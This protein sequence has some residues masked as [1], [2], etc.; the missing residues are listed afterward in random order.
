VR[1]DGGLT[2]AY[3]RRAVALTMFLMVD[4]VD[5]LSD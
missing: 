4:V 3:A 1:V 2:F 5:D